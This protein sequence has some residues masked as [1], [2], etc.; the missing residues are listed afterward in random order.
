MFYHGDVNAKSFAIN[1]ICSLCP[2]KSLSGGF[3]DKGQLSESPFL[4]HPKDNHTAAFYQVFDP[5]QKISSVNE[6]VFATS[7]D[8]IKFIVCY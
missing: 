1:L 6:N 5:S 8:W 2:L 3:Y 4:L 7:D